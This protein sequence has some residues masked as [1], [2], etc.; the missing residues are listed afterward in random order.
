ML[1][2]KYRDKRYLSKYDLSI[3]LFDNFD[4]KVTDVIPVRNVFI[5]C[6]DKG[7]KILKKIEYSIEELHFIY[8]AAKY[9]SRKF[10]RILNF[11][12]TRDGNIYVSYDKDIYCV[13]D[14]V[15]GRECD[16]NN[17]IDLSIASRGLGEFHKASEG[18]RHSFTAKDQRGKLIEN[19]RRR[20]SEMDF[21]ES[22]ANIHEN[23]SEFDSIFL[24]NLPY[25]R[26]QMEKSI[27]ALN[28]SS[29][30]KLCSEEDKVVL[31]HNDLAHHNILIYG[32]AAYF[33]DFD[34][35]VIDLKVHDLCN[36]INKVVKSFAFDI[37]KARSILIDYGSQNSLD[38][39][40]VEVLYDLLMFPE[41]FYSISKDYYT[42]RKDW[43]EEVFLG[44]L[45]RKIESREDRQEF[46]NDFMKELF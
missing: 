11:N 13:M 26:Q 16:F 29:Y 4:F 43:E 44:K 40:E 12:K 23:K 27:E 37:E 33:I 10:N 5:L 31:C 6:T 35:S 9:V 19:F 21:F 15:Q 17:C 39:R 38:K 45:K 1:E 46:L 25:H 32:E 14:L 24:E 20:L 18:F 2:S 28:K 3:D 34:Y 22:I 8:S 7:D 41:D 42:R 30:L 36:F